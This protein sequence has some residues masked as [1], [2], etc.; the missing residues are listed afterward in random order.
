MKRFL[1]SLAL[2]FILALPW[3]GASAQQVNNY[4]C[5]SATVPCPP[6]A[7]T[8]ASAANAFPVTGT[9]AVT[10]PA[11]TNVATAALAT[12]LVVKNSAASLYSFNVSADS[13]L[14]AAAWWILILNA[15]TDP[16]SGSVTPARCY[17]MPSG[18][19]NF[20]AAFPV[21]LPFATGIVIVAST[22]G[23]FTEATSAH[24]FIAGDFK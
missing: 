20:S 17:A 24:A 2:G 1:K 7:W 10:E 19:T 14:S 8:P 15:T 22:N 6:S 12:S 5:N 16:G 3:V 9:L 18:T 21:G 23:C 11:T 4:W 13:T